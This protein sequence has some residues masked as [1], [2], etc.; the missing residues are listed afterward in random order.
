MSVR[1]RFRLNGGVLQPQQVV[2][3]ALDP[4]V[5]GVEQVVVIS[6]AN[7]VTIMNQTAG[8]AELRNAGD[9]ATP[10]ILLVVPRAMIALTHQPWGRIITELGTER[11]LRSFAESLMS[12]AARRGRKS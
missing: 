3:V 10:Y 5:T 2:Q 9:V 11:G 4:P 1:D 8:V 12:L 7:R 6:A